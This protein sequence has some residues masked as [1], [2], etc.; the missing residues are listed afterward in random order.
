M[1]QLRGRKENALHP[2]GLQDWEGPATR[3]EGRRR[4]VRDQTCV[5]DLPTSCAALLFLAIF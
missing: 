5:R 3:P 2:Y 4:R 1:A